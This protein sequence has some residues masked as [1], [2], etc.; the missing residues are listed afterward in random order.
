MEI[1]VSQMGLN[2]EGKVVST[3]GL[4]MTDEENGKELDAGGRAC[5]RSWT[6][7][8]SCLSQDRYELRG[9]RTGETDAAA[10]HQ[11]HASPH[12]SGAIP[13]GKSEMLDCVQQ[14]S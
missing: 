8:A 14:T 12:T 10:E 1:L 3:L 5:H 6:M 4:R 13:E 11:E 2:S 9:E 7:R